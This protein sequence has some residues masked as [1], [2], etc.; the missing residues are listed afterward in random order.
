MKLPH[1]GLPSFDYIRAQT[2]N[3]VTELLLTNPHET[4]L[5]M[6]GTDIFGQMRSGVF[7]AKILVDV[8]HLP[9]MT[10]IEFDPVNGLQVGAAVNMN[11]LA[12]H[13]AVRENYPL[14]S[15]A[16]STIAS[17]QIRNRATI[18]GNL[19]NA[20]PCADTAPAAL[21]LEANL[22]A[23]GPAGERSIPIREFF[24]GPGEHVLEQ[25]EF[26]ARIEFP[27]PPVGWAG[28]Y[29]KL[30]R[31]AEGDLAV[32][33][34]AVMGYPDESASSGY[35]FRMALGSVAP[36][37]I[38]VPKAEHLLAQGPISESTLDHAARLA[39]ETARP[40]DDVRASAR[41]RSAMVERLTQR[42]LK[43]VWA[44]LNKES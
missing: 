42:C 3:Q 37:P 19:C 27:M 20:S 41:Y 31:N 26:L 32:V 1:S 17:Y 25:G 13:S 15:E 9:G 28:R 8:K 39:R 12:S 43:G 14:L 16:A 7:E 34:V 10:T 40:I 44:L 30:G 36:T 22:I 18:G 6:G 38:R 33:S 21:V 29:C 2:S 24:T 23:W 35:R 4:R 5:F 11:Q